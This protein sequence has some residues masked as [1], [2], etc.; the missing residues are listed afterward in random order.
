MIIMKILAVLFALL[1]VTKIVM[2]VGQLSSMILTMAG[3]G[4]KSPSS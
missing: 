4:M 2:L 1:I 3:P